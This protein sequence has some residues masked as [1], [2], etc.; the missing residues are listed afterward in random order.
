MA[1]P[2][3]N[4][5]TS[6][7][8]KMLAEAV[9]VVTPDHEEWQERRERWNRFSDEV[10]TRLIA[11]PANT[12]D[13]VKIV[14][15]AREN[16]Q[17][18]LGVR[19]GGHGYFSTADTVIDMRDGFDY[20]SVDETTGIATIGMG[21]TLGALDERT[22]PWHVPV[23]VVSHTGTGLL[24]T[25]GVGYL[26][27]A[28]GT[29]SDNITEVTIVT[30][31]GKVHICS[32]ENEPDLFFAVR[33]AAPNLGIVTEVKMQAYLHPDALC[34]LRA[35]PLS[36]EN[37]Q[38]LVDWADQPDVL[39]DPNMTPY[40]ALIPS[41][42]FKARLV[43][44]QLVYAG[45]AEADERIM[46]LLG[47]L[48]DTGEMVLLPASRVPWQVPQTI[49]DEAFGNHYWYVTQAYFP[50][51]QT[52][53]TASLQSEIENFSKVPLGDFAP[54][55]IFE[56][57]GSASSRYHQFASDH[58]AQPRHGQRWECYVFV[59]CFDARHAEDVRKW[60]RVCKDALLDSG[61]SAGGRCHF[62]T[63]EPSRI[64]F[65]YGDNSE[66]VR[67]IVAKYDPNRLFASCNGM[68][69]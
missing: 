38:R 3:I 48:D 39:N 50:G 15:W 11:V 40:I 7:A 19:A 28:H 62:T 68:A 54:S 29:S 26:C 64:E 53:P 21:Q 56:Q 27:K 24:L 1:S 8:E 52:I 57:R 60:G 46:E 55:V 16:D 63:D 51:D 14:N 33:G 69:F 31:D 18:N 45:P 6:K 67:Q 4:G 61:A 5:N 47:Q 25:G 35:W 43:A 41:P 32:E 22:H 65:Y 44:L 66:R 30:S 23:G 12:E 9:K 10:P 59:A 58:C 2:S 42:D 20:A 17:N 49:F 36:E 37:T 34:S 13:V